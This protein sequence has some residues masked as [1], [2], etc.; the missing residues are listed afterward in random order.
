[1]AIRGVHTVAH[2]A[3]R[4]VTDIQT[5]LCSIV[6]QL[7]GSLTLEALDGHSLRGPA[8]A[9]LFMKSWECELRLLFNL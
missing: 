2:V 5:G 7:F 4:F 3:F 6:G 9:T 1:M 8:L